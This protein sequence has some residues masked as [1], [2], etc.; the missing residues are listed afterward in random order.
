MEPQP[1]ED[2]PRPTPEAD[3]P[4]GASEA[5]AS[6]PHAPRARPWEIGPIVL[7]SGVVLYF[8]WSRLALRAD[9]LS[10]P[11]SALLSIPP[12]W[13]WIPVAVVG[14]VL[15]VLALACAALRLSD[16]PVRAF[17]VFAAVT[18]FLQVFVLP[19]VYLPAMITAD[20]T[21]TN[22]LRVVATRLGAE[23][24]DG[25]LPVDPETLARAVD[26]LPP[27]PYQRQGAPVR[28]WHIVLRTGCTGPARQAEGLGIGTVLYC[29]A[30][31]GHHGWLTFVG[32]G[33]RQV[34]PAALGRDA[35]GRLIALPVRAAQ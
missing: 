17:Y 33:G 31:G 24:D 26:G 5:D 19:D 23:A 8:V 7:L 35:D 25:R 30:E 4:G 20:F 14:A 3:A 1:V 11:A 2:V 21:A 22:A 34:G 29:L 18:L 13:F 16:R 32:T 28:R 10:Q 27:P 15:A 12:A 9:A 6:R